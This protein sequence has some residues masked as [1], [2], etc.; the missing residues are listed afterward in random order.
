ML[1]AASW[2]LPSGGFCFMA[3]MLDMRLCCSGGVVCGV[4]KIP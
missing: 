3:V 4:M 2:R 1:S